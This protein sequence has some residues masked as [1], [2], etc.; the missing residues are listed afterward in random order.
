MSGVCSLFGCAFET[1]VVALSPF[2]IHCWCIPFLL[3]CTM[4]L[5]LILLSSSMLLLY[6]G[7]FFTHRWRN[8]VNFFFF[9]F[10]I[11]FSNLFWILFLSQMLS[12]SLSVYKKMKIKMIFLIGHIQKRNEIQTFFQSN[13]SPYRHQRFTITWLLMFPFL[14]SQWQQCHERSYQ[15]IKCML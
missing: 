1:L 12:F 2:I 4:F 10:R 6:K 5:V 15:Y 8:V 7:D 13:T 3:T 11:Q 9:Y 14:K